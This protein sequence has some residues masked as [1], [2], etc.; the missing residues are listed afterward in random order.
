MFQGSIVRGIIK[1]R[2]SPNMKNTLER[3]LSK[4]NQK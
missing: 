4:I 1:Q 3:H 2:K